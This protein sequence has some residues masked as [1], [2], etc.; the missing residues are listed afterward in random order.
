MGETPTEP[1][2]TRASSSSRATASTRSRSP[3]AC[4]RS[5]P[6][7]STRST[8]PPT[9]TP[10]SCAAPASRSRATSTARQLSYKLQTDFGR[11]VV[12]RK[13]FHV[14]VKLGDGVWLRVGQWK[15]PFS[16]QHIHSSGRHEL[17]DRAI[18]DNVFGAG[19]DIGLGAAQRLREVARPRVDRRRVQRHRRRSGAAGR[20]PRTTARSPAPPP[21]CP[22]SSARPGRSRRHQRRRHQGLQRGRPRGRAAALGRRRERVARGRLRRGRRLQPEGR[23]RLHREGQWLLVHR[24]LLRHD[25][26]ARP[27]AVRRSGALARRLSP[28][29]RLHADARPRRWW[30]ATR[31]SMPRPSSRTARSRTSRRSRSAATTSPSVTTPSWQGAVRFIKTG[32]A[33]FDRRVLVEVGANVGF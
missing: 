13:D 31:S 6:A 11:G 16:R 14:D 19:R 21:T 8:S 30:R 20:S 10:S 3:A 1:A 15:R 29:G 7:P 25:Q 4:S 32:D 26:P 9:T 2:T 5:T 18:T 17:S 23:A 28:P 24:R 33:S 12:L 22:A 27:Q